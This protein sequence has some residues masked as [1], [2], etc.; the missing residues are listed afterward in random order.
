VA[1]LLL[2]TLVGIPSIS[3]SSEGSDGVSQFRDSVVRGWHWRPESGVALTSTS[4]ARD[5]LEWYRKRLRNLTDYADTYDVTESD[6]GVVLFQTSQLDLVVVESAQPTV[7]RLVVMFHR[8]DG[9][10][11]FSNEGAHEAP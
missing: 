5:Y 8:T 7:P 11:V 1:V 4:Y 10:R 2:V 3:S 9:E 6:R